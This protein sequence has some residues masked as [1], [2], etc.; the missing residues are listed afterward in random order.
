MNKTKV[1]RILEY[2]GIQKEFPFDVFDVEDEESVLGY[3]GIH[4]ELDDE[5]RG[6]IRA[7]LLEMAGTAQ[8]AEIARIMT[9]EPEPRGLYRCRYVNRTTQSVRFDEWLVSLPE[10]LRG[11]FGS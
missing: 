2:I 9:V 7:G 3:Y 4:P 8:T 11:G 5:E 1:N 6:E 10:G